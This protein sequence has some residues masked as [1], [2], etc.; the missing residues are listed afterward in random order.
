VRRFLPLI[1]LAIAAG[2]SSSKPPAPRAVHEHVTKHFVVVVQEHD[3][4]APDDALI[5]RPVAAGPL[6]YASEHETAF[7][8]HDTRYSVRIAWRRDCLD[9]MVA[10]Q[11]LAPFDDFAA[12]GC[13]QPRGP[14]T[15][16]ATVNG[17]S[18]APIEV[19]VWVLET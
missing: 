18:G 6:S 14:S 10:R 5:T 7:A 2:C 13:V 11:G 15:P 1:I 3:P 17:P 8:T 4:L 16:V 9:V 12:H 19:L